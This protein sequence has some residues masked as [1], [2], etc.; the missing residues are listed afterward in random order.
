MSAG[1]KAKAPVLVSACLLGEPCRYDGKACFCEAVIAFA[2]ECE[3]VPV[4]PEQLGGLPTPRTCCEIQCD[5][6]VVDQAGADRT[7]AFWKGARETVRIARERG[8]QQAILKSH[9]PSCGVHEVYDG[10][11]TGVLVPGAGKAAAAL[12]AAGLAV[13]DELDLNGT[14]APGRFVP[15]MGGACDG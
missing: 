14:N 9:S 4:C 8:C 15:G 10:S 7:A 1:G 11:F 6:R 3:V 13:S 2:R 12:R 5:G